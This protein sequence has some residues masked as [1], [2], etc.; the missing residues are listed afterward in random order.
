MKNIIWL[1]FDLLNDDNFVAAV[2]PFLG[3]IVA[4]YPCHAPFSPL[5]AHFIVAAYHNKNSFTSFYHRKLEY[6]WEFCLDIIA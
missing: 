4:A 6:R 2:P 3:G 1:Y 5:R